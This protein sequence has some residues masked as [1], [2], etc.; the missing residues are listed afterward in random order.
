MS[1]LFDYIKKYILEVRLFVVEQ[2]R[3][4]KEMLVY[5]W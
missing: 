4:N 2:R 5:K 3:T 1:A